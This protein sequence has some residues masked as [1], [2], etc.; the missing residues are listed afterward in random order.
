MSHCA[1]MA[2][3]KRKKDHP[4]FKAKEIR[5]TSCSKLEEISTVMYYHEL[6]D[7]TA[8]CTLWKTQV[9]KIL[10]FQEKWKIMSL[11]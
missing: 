9:F 2:R 11:H 5:C 10:L 3:L 1:S 8:A 4:L 6:D 7:D